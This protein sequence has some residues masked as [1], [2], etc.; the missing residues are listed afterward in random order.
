[1]NLLGST[2]LQVGVAREVLVVAYERKSLSDSYVCQFQPR[3][4]KSMVV[5]C[6]QLTIV[7]C[8]IPRLNMKQFQKLV[9]Q[10]TLFYIQHLETVFKNTSI[11]DQL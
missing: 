11:P 1:M 7:N 4:N 9:V 5:F 8:K 10:G 6:F 2:G 3:Q